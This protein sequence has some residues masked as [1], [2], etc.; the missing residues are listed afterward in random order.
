MK[1]SIITVNYNNKKG[2]KDT[3]ESIIHQSFQD[4]EFI[5]I[6]GGSTDGSTEV[7]KEYSK[8]TTYWVS[9][10][11]SGIYNGMNKG[12]LHA[13]GEYVNFMN[14]GD[15]FYN[16]QV[17]N[18]V[19]EFIEGQD[20][21]VGKDFHQNPITKEHATTQ[22]PIRKSMAMF[23]IQTIPH[24][25]AFIRRALFEGHPYDETL[26]IVADW[27]F[28][29]DKIIIEGKSLQFIDTIICRREQ[30]GISVTRNDETL[31]ERKKVLKDFLPIGIYQDYESLSQLD[32]TT[33][34]KFLNLCDDVKVRKMLVYVVKII[35]RLRNLRKSF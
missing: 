7:I 1:F 22:L 21:I 9:E 32:P 20:F 18:I 27:K 16:N 3:I 10:K 5:I 26:R 13:N 6:D 17:L 14:S 29:L 35:Y 23:Y 30:G 2:L 19:S 15:T 25:S 11:D 8:Y 24:Q 34:Y 12:I 33:L 4:Y 31:R 28:Y